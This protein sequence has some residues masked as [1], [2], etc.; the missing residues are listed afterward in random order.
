[1]G[2]EGIFLR[3]KDEYHLVI[4]VTLLQ[5]AISVVIETEAVA[6]MFSG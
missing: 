1:M 6:P 4:S 2:A 3:V 5:R